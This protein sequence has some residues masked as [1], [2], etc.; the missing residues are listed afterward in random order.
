MEVV[1]FGRNLDFR[2]AVHR[3]ASGRLG[4]LRT[5]LDDQLYILDTKEKTV[6]V[7]AEGRSATRIRLDEAPASI[8]EPVDLAVDDLGDL[9]ICDAASGRV[10]VLDP[11]GKTLLAGLRADKAKG[12]L[13]APDRIEVD[14]Q[15]RVYVYDR[16]ADAILRYH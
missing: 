13:L 14:H 6:T 16:K 15:G 8:M 2:A 11:T 10:V 12:G 7:Y 4:P 9:Y 5:G 1:Q 3:S